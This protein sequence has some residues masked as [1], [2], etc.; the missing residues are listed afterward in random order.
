MPAAGPTGSGFALAR[1]LYLRPMAQE[2]EVLNR[3]VPGTMMEALGIRFTLV[4]PGYVEATMPVDDRTHQP[5]GI[6]HGGA[7]AALAE[8]IASHGS[9]LLVVG[10]N[11]M[12]V[13]VELNI[14]HLKSKSEGVVTGKAQILHQGRSTHVWS[15]DV[16]DESGSRIAVSRLTVLIKDRKP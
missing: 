8:T 1:P 10:Q 14:N 7:S 13:G 15:I 5:Y 16:V 3:L 2:N 11:K 12:C 9:A 6:L 4:E